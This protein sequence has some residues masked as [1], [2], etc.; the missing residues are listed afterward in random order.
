MIIDNE[1]EWKVERILQHRKQ[2]KKTQYLIYWKGFNQEE[3][4]WETENNLKNAK[5][6]LKEYKSLGYATVKSIEENTIDTNIKLLR[7]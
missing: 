3:D 6:K 7:Q 1:E 4:T 5:G 2:G